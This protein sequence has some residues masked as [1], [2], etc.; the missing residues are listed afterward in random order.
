M[1]LGV[2]VEA[3]VSRVRGVLDPVYGSE[4]HVMVWERNADFCAYMGLDPVEVLGAKPTPLPVREPL[5]TVPTAPSL[6]TA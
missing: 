5:W 1:G 4:R 6:A 2:A 3:G